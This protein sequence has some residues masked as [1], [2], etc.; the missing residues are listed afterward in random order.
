VVPHDFVQ[1][2]VALTAAASV[3]GVVVDRA[4]RPVPSVQVR[5]RDPARAPAAQP[6]WLIWAVA[7]TDDAATTSVP[8]CAPRPRSPSPTTPP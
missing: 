5:L 4:G 6:P 1:L 7:T 2:D 8:R 3:S